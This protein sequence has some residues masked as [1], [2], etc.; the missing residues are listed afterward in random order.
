MNKRKADVNDIPILVELR[1]K[2]LIDEGEELPLSSPLYL[3]R[4]TQTAVQS[5]SVSS[6]S[7]CFLQSE[8]VAD[9]RARRSQ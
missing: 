8:R 3:Q 1:K 5:A 6:L 7:P 9:L 2:Q 4:K